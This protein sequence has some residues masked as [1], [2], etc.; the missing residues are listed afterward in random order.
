MISD[1]N[2]FISQLGNRGKISR[3]FIYTWIH[4]EKR[5]AY[6]TFQFGWCTNRISYLGHF[7]MFYYVLHSVFFKERDTSQ[8]RTKL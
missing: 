7:H 4:K 3:L 6:E 8:K 2:V 5:V 1:E